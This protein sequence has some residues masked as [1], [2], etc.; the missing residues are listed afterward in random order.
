MLSL[1]W[2]AW[3]SGS[4]SSR[5]SFLSSPEGIY[6]LQIPSDPSVDLVIP[7][8][9]QLT[10]NYSP[11]K[12][13]SWQEG[14]HRRNSHQQTRAFPTKTI[15]ENTH[16]RCVSQSRSSCR[17]SSASHCL[18]LPSA[19]SAA[20]PDPL[21]CSATENFHIKLPTPLSQLLYLQEPSSASPHCAWPGA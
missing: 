16:K 20:A 19:T 17:T 2:T 13:Q 7:Q 10:A 14:M 3:D 8:P 21:P 11:K 9:R 6:I 18:L 15:E 1:R 5:N 4:F 12:R